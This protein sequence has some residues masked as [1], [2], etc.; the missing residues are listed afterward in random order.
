MNSTLKKDLDILYIHPTRSLSSTL[1]S[2]MP[3]GIF[4]LLNELKNAGYNVK[5]INLGI[6]L[7][8]RKNYD[9]KCELE[10][11][12]YKI[13]LIDLHWYEHC[14]GSIEIAQLSKNLKPNI[15]VVVGGFTATIYS[16]EI[17]KNFKC[18]DYIL[19]GDS[20]LPLL[21]LV[22]FLI[23]K[24]DNPEYIENLCYRNNGEIIN[25]K[26]SYLCNNFNNLDFITNDFLKN[27][28][29]YYY[30]FGNGLDGIQLKS[31]WLAIARGCYNNCSYCC[32]SKENLNILFG[33][34]TIIK[35]TPEVV[36]NDIKKLS[37][38]GVDVI[39]PT[40]D[41]QMFGAKYF[42]ELFSKV[43]ALR[44]SIG[45]YLES[46]SL[47]S[48]N[49]LLDIMDT[50]NLN[51]SIIIISP[52]TGD[53]T[54]RKKNGKYFS[55][56]E[57]Y[58]F[59]QFATENNINVQLYYSMNIP[60]EDNKT[61]EKTLNQM[62][63]IFKNYKVK[64]NMMTCQIVVLDPLA[65]ARSILPINN[66]YLNSFLDYYNYCKSTD[67]YF[68]GYLDKNCPS[69]KLKT[70]QYKLFLRKMSSQMDSNNLFSELNS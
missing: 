67:P 4:A 2:T 61:F 36:A 27:K 8:I 12:N 24:I 42:E 10:S 16:Y 11:L 37:D 62:E 1:F 38:Y 14:Y 7:S 26:I 54:L 44:L 68:T 66:T 41:F 69:I 50:F 70:Q 59:L 57:L 45:L 25:K 47:P 40:H 31:F 18:I 46:F 64:L 30:D 17:L 21:K 55:N 5:G 49:Y 48:K 51:K 53:E 52:L 34:T 13:L 3:V 20:E 56:S 15:P 22:N 28:N 32:G 58:N 23:K 19:K 60:G 29:Y 33:R 6:E 9:L 63:Y 39:C 65:P 35:R 43:R